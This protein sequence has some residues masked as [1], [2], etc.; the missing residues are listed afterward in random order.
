MVVPMDDIHSN[1]VEQKGKPPAVLRRGRSLFVGCSCPTCGHRTWLTI[2][3][4]QVVRRPKR[5][6]RCSGCGRLGELGVGK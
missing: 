2:A 6:Y 4:R 1:P 3:V 5:Q